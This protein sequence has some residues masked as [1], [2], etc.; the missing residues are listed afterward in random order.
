MTQ[1]KVIAVIA[2]DIVK[3]KSL[4][5]RR[6]K[7]FDGLLRAIED[8]RN[9]L[10]QKQC[11]LV[12]SGIYRG[13]SFQ[14]AL[15]DPRQALW[16]AIFLR[17]ELFK[18]RGKGLKTD[19]RLGLGLGTASQWNEKNIS[20]SDGEAFQLSG[21]ALDLLKS[22]KEKYRRLYIASPWEDANRIFSVLAV[23]MDALIQRWTFAQAQALSLF[24]IDKA[25]EDT[26][27]VLHISQPATQNRLQTAGHFAVKEA[28]DFFGYLVEKQKINQGIY[29]PIL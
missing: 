25:Q 16:T 8:A 14:C 27:R 5:D 4:Q 7:V 19:V 15:S 6:K 26:S 17:A 29:N 23:L 1:G 12:F 21:K 24:L 13:D 9:R 2:G 10:E 3:S 18:L 20:A 28:I 22:A 11:K